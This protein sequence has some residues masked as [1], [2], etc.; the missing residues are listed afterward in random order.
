MCVCAEI[1]HPRWIHH[2][3]AHRQTCP[4]AKP[5][6]V[7]LSLESSLQRRPMG[8]PSP[9]ELFIV[10]TAL[11]SRRASFP[12]ACGLSSL[13]GPADMEGSVPVGSSPPL[14]A[15]DCD[16]E[17]FLARSRRW[18]SWKEARGAM[19]PLCLAS[20]RPGCSADGV[21][22]G[23]QPG[24]LATSSS[25]GRMGVGLQAPIYRMRSFV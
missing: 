2:V 23:P 1:S 9:S 19:A 14:K 15:R 18:A 7:S 13:P 6:H 20:Q 16:T 5:T 3:E 10:L 25:Y 21:A 24:G 8:Q 12:R 4:R 22:L 11:S 17:A